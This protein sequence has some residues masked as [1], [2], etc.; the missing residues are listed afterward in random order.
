VTD[1]NDLRSRL[2]RIASV[3]GDPPEHGLDRVA[4]RRHRRLRR[5]RGAV[6]AAAVLAVV[7]VAVPL[8]RHSGSEDRPSVAASGTAR[9]GGVSPEVPRE[10]VVRCEQTGIV[11][12]VASVR[13]QSD[14][15]HIRVFNDLAAPTVVEV[16]SARWSSGEIT[17]RP[18][19]HRVR[20]PVPPGEVTIGCRIAGEM[21]RRRVDLVDPAG[22]Y[23]EPELQCADG[24]EV[25]ELDDL[26][27]E[28]QSSN[29]FR[30]ARTALDSQLVDGT[31]DDAVGALRGYPAQRASDA[32]ADP[33]VQVERSGRVIAFA[34]V[35]G[36]DGATSAPWVTVD[37]QVC[38]SV[39]LE[40]EP[41]DT[42]T[43]APTTGATG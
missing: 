12:P 10:I 40:S 36:A 20:Q 2:E 29:I 23:V 31:R 25:D 16:D 32:S 24:D 42:T 5:R 43:T 14:G 39:V 35:R 27:V 28:P 34:S 22:Y 7:T 30:A 15:L 4:A 21:Q 11:V 3:A 13:P 8:I 33:T 38:S 18:G 6:A 9:P 19:E 37:A 26:P 1:D 17:V 41:D